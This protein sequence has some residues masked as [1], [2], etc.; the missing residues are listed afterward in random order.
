[1]NAFDQAHEKS[2]RHRPILRDSRTARGDDGGGILDAERA[3][4]GHDVESARGSGEERRRRNCGGGDAPRFDRGDPQRVGTRLNEGHIFRAEAELLDRRAD[5]DL[6]DAADARYGGALA[7]Q[8][9]G[10]TDAAAR[11]QGVRHQ[12]ID[13]RENYDGRA[14][15]RRLDRRGRAEIG[16]AY[17]VRHHRLDVRET[18]GDEDEIRVQTVFLEHARVVGHPKWNVL[19][20]VARIAEMH[21]LR[22]RGQRP[23]ERRDDAER[24]DPTAGCER[25]FHAAS[26]Y[27]L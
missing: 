21:G 17:L 13:R 12:A 4:I 11:D 27:Y 18:A 1:M 26:K 25:L 23:G 2:F 3:Q 9:G 24:R 22:A 8:I 6:L 14:L 7:F 16:E 15:G 5:R 19:S 20:R 10:G